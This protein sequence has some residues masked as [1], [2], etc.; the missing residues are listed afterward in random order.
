MI[1]IQK[2]PAIISPIRI[3]IG[4][5]YLR[6]TPMGKIRLQEVVDLA[7]NAWSD[8]LA[9]RIEGDMIVL[10][11]KS[12]DGVS[13]DR[14]PAIEK[15]IEIV[16][17]A[18]VIIFIAH[19]NRYQIDPMGYD[20]DHQFLTYIPH[21]SMFVDHYLW[22]AHQSTK[23]L[24]S[25]LVGEV[26]VDIIPFPRSDL[27]YK[28][29]SYSMDNQLVSEILSVFTLREDL[30]QRF[31]LRT[32]YTAEI[33]NGNV[34]TIDAD[35]TRSG[36]RDKI[37]VEFHG[38]VIFVKGWT[39]ANA[40]PNHENIIIFYIWMKSFYPDNLFLEV[41]FNS[42]SPVKLIKNS[43][44]S[45]PTIVDALIKTRLLNKDNIRETGAIKIGMYGIYKY[46][47]N[48]SGVV[49]ITKSFGRGVVQ[50]E[51]I[52]RGHNKVEIVSADQDTLNLIADIIDQNETLYR[53]N[54]RT[55]TNMLIEAIAKRD[56]YFDIMKLYFTAKSIRGITLVSELD[57][58][59]ITVGSDA[60]IDISNKTEF[61]EGVTPIHIVSVDRTEGKYDNYL[62]GG[63]N[64]INAVLSVLPNT[65]RQNIGLHEI[66]PG[67]LARRLRNDA[68][69]YVSFLLN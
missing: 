2:F 45:T 34:D 7:G 14:R 68:Y 43:L 59:N 69:V 16:N 58:V 48:N 41:V 18:V 62:I 12:L 66:R 22:I 5:N 33:V 3:S 15:F 21:K 53:I 61:G 20:V 11:S 35:L 8:L 40:T 4:N 9:D 28:V 64:A 10:E 39:D 63:Q 38:N 44:W 65:V 31:I 6:Y 47:L 52:V 32:Q 49:E 25:R 56:R 19:R 67:V 1:E 30:T 37:S 24:I 29:E 55:M 13:I 26:L 57:P 54:S 23:E 60:L 42:F 36:L 50:S 46:P 51:F 27:P 17:L